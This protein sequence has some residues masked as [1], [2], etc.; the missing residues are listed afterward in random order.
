MAATVDDVVRRLRAAGCVFAEAEARLLLS[1]D[2]ELESLIARRIAGE[3]LEVIVGFA[4]FCGL[5]VFV[6]PGVFVPR[7]RSELLVREAVARVSPGSVVLDLCCGTGAL[8]AA[9]LDRVPVELYSADLDPVAVRCARRNVSPV[10]EGD[11]FDALPSFLRG[12]VDVIVCNAPYVPTD[13]I[14]FMPVEARE[15]EPSTALDGG[16]DGVEV[17]RRV[18]AEA[19]EWLRPGGWLLIETSEHQAP[20]TAAAFVGLTTEVI[21]SDEL[22]CTVVVGQ[23]NQ[24]QQAPVAANVE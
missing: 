24:D 18:A 9:V 12:A 22:S 4:E 6:E 2:G 15:H 10:F 14:A 1:A 23:S 5:R 19:V 17:H 7:R 13:E 11:L 20:S 21:T 3:P 16:A 8:G